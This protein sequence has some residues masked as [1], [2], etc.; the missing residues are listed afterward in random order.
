MRGSLATFQKRHPP[1]SGNSSGVL[2][3]TRHIPVSCH[4]RR[5]DTCN[6]IISCIRLRR[7]EFCRVASFTIFISSCGAASSRL[8]P[9]LKQV[10][11]PTSRVQMKIMLLV[12]LF[13]FL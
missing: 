13:V 3:P 10:S 1:P 6:L 8:K 2:H 5:A 11:Q 7:Q 12:I 9:F 4:L